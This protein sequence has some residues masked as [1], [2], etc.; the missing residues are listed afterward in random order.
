MFAN[1]ISFGKTVDEDYELAT[2]VRQLKI[3]ARLL[4]IGATVKYA[5]LHSALP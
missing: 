5:V 3:E 1:A 4:Q 2:N